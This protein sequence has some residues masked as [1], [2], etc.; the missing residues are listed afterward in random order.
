MLSLTLVFRVEAGGAAALAILPGPGRELGQEV[1]R[2]VE[3]SCPAFLVAQFVEEPAPEPILF[4]SWQGGQ[5][6]DRRIE[7]SGHGCSIRETREGERRLDNGAD[8]APEF[9]HDN[10]RVTA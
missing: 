10:I 5:L 7:R 2:G 3:R 6:G 8:I 9:L 1:L 4:V